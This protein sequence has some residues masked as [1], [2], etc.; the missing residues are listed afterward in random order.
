M[1]KSFLWPHRSLVK[2][3]R[4]K[5]QVC[6]FLRF[7]YVLVVLKAKRLEKSSEK[8]QLSLDEDQVCHHLLKYFVFC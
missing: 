3:R 1:S 7:V 5:S 8:I 2:E 4:V 6:S